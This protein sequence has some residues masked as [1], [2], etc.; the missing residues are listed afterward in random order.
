MDVLERRK[1]IRG[2]YAATTFADAQI[3]R[4][5]AELKALDLEENT[6]V[7]FWADHGWSLGEHG[8]WMKQTLFEPAT[9]VPTLFAGPGTGKPGQVCHRTTE[10]LD[11]YPTLVELC[12]LEGAPE[13]L[14]GASLVPL[15]KN[16]EARREKP[17]IS[18]VARPP[19][20]PKT[21]GYSLRNERYRYT[22]WEGAETGEELYDY[23]NDPH[24]WTN[25][26][27]DAGA[28]EVK[29]ELKAQLA[30]ITARRGRAPVAG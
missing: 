11:I 16:P 24:E 13:N 19:L 3:G 1:A 8:Q 10:H 12:G 20:K 9:R 27:D 28:R 29:A 6:I 7:V 21:V 15:L 17:S 18:Q 26:A 4:V 25:L 23:R 22:A 30:E 5:L 2:Y 14:Q